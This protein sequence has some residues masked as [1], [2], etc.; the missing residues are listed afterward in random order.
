[1]I[2]KLNLLLFTWF[3]IDSMYRCVA[4]FLVNNGVDIYCRFSVMGHNGIRIYVTTTITQSKLQCVPIHYSVHI[5][6]CASTP[7]KNTTN[8]SCSR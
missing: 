8:A 1:M 4:L 3:F 6:K 5:S 7:R 2:Q